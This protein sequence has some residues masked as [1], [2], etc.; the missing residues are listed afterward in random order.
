MSRLATR[1]RGA[2]GRA[3]A[4]P[5]VAYLTDFAGEGPLARLVYRADD[6][7]VWELAYSPGS[8]WE[9]ADLTCAGGEPR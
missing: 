5:P 4:Q 9:S 8:G 3:A 2:G 1:P 6:G 7:H